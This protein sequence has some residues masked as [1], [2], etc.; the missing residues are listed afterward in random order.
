MSNGSTTDALSS[1]VRWIEAMMLGTIAT[2]LA[3]LA[4]A[5]LGFLMLQ[6]RLD[7]K[8]AAR[9]IVG[10]FLIFGAPVISAGL[11]GRIDNQPAYSRSMAAPESDM[12]PPPP[13][14]NEQFD[15]YAGA[16]V[17]RTW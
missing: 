5:V 2:T 9:V 6:G 15:P 8:R 12:P 4:I 16:A 17:Q 11:L 13:R 14:K 7:W 1:A 10:C 3:I